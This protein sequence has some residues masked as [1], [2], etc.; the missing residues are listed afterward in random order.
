MK[1]LHEHHSRHM[2]KRIG[3]VEGTFTANVDKGILSFYVGRDSSAFVKKS[4]LKTILFACL[5]FHVYF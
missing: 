2:E 3:S 5:D 1:N 4:Y